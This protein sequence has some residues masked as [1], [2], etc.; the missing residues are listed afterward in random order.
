M[1]FYILDSELDIIDVV[2]T[3]K[4]VIWT[5]RYW[6]EGDF[7][8]YVPATEKMIA[9]LQ[10]DRFIVRMDD[11]TQCMIIQDVQITTNIEDGNYLTVIGKDLKNL[12][13]RRIVWKQITLSGFCEDAIRNLV[14]VN[15][16]DP[17]DSDR[18][19]SNF[20]LG[21]KAG[22]THKMKMQF[23]GQSLNEAISKIC[24]VQKL[25]Y[26]VT[27]DLPN[28]Q[29]V[30]KLYE[31]K[32]RSFN[33]STNPYVVFSKDFENLISTDYV[34]NGSQFRNVA[35]VAGEGE[36]IGRKNAVVGTASGLSRYEMYVDIRDTSTNEGEIDALT[37]QS[38]LIEKGASALA[39]TLYDETI[40]GEVEPN[41]TFKLGED[42]FLGDVVEIVN[43][44]GIE[45]TPRITET[46]ESE[47]DSGHY[48]IPTFASD[49]SVE[50]D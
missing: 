11:T 34:N 1:E 15:I 20:V 27:L 13:D 26:D 39:Q 19:I 32:D 17:D 33:Q 16:I 6:D 38:I 22:I 31:G 36:G 30:F 40:D 23:T 49:D 37:Y 29:F 18:Q 3:F 4:S 46:I 7:E 24:K 10:R 45:M 12:L 9:L 44:Y 48:T 8:L 42:Y 25:G 14:T 35:K 50:I 2:D 41:N 21:A 28:K 47:D 5:R 43:E